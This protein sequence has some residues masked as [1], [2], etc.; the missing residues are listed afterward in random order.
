MALE[1]VPGWVSSVATAPAALW[2]V[3]GNVLVSQGLA[4][5][6]SLL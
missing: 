2:F 1:L 3:V 4:L 5:S 6:Q